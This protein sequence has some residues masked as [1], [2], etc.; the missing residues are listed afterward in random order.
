MKLVALPA[1]KE[2]LLG[3]DRVKRDK[4]AKTCEIVHLAVHKSSIVHSTIPHSSP[5]IG[6][7]LTTTFVI[8]SHGKVPT[9]FH[10]RTVDYIP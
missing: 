4:E 7:I 1:T 5:A 8:W 2:T 6:V 3:S 9:W 10:A